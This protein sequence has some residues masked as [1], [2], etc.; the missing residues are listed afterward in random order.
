MPPRKSWTTAMYMAP[1][2]ITTKPTGKH[3]KAPHRGAFLI[4]QCL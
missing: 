2:V 3:K 4:L 1:M